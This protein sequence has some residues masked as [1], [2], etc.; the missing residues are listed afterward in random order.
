MVA[1]SFLTACLSAFHYTLSLSS[2]TAKA[3]IVGPF[4]I[5][6]AVVKQFTD[7][8]YEICNL[9]IYKMGIKCVSV[10]CF[11]LVVGIKGEKR[12]RKHLERSRGK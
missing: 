2:Q 6:H 8:V 7:H 1:L 4:G 5:Q 12:T 10:T 3:S 9:K 11:R